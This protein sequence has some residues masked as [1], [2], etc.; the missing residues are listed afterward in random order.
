MPRME[1]A[2][3][4]KVTTQPEGLLPEGDSWGHTKETLHTQGFNKP[5]W[6]SVWMVGAGRAFYGGVGGRKEDGCVGGEPFRGGGCM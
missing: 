6:P 1:T 4:G 3:T 5:S 2:V